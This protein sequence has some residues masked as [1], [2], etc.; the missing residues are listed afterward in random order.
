MCS[1]LLKSIIVIQIFVQVEGAFD[2]NGLH[3]RVDVR[4][5]PSL[6]HAQKEAEV[7]A[8][9]ARS[10]VV[11]GRMRGRAESVLVVPLPQYL[12]DVAVNEQARGASCGYADDLVAR[13]LLV[14]HETYVVLNSRFLVL[15]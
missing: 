6:R 7:F 8:V 12:A 4:V 2:V 5:Q 1:T 10:A 13:V 9:D 3:R 14:G 11:A 15:D